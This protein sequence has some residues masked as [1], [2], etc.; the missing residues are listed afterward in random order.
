MPFTKKLDV[1]IR[2]VAWKAPDHILQYNI[3]TSSTL[4][5]TKN[6]EMA[7]I[8]AM[9]FVFAFATLQVLALFKMHLSQ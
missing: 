8:W 5:V 7:D 3:L 6:G 4:C 9:F 1:Q 2:L